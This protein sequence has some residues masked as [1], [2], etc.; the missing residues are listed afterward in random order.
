MRCRLSR[1]VRQGLSLIVLAAATMGPYVG[2]GLL[3]ARPLG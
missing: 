2:P 3:A 1:E